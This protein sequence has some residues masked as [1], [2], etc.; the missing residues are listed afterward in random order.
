MA[1]V[2]ELAT[3]TEAATRYKCNPR[4]IRR[5]IDSGE[6]GVYRIGAKIVRIDIAET[7]AA[8]FKAGR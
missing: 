6:I 5:L 7:D 1:V 2:P 4:T 8:F 3:I